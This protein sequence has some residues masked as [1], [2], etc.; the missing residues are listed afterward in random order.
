MAVLG[1]PNPVNEV[2]ARVGAVL[3]LA[4]ALLHFAAGEDAAA[5]VLVGLVLVAAT[6]E[7]V[8]ALCLGCL[9]GSAG[10]RHCARRRTAP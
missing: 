5:A 6:L 1:F 10:G 9:Q 3:T 4:A 7:S 8:F 2:A